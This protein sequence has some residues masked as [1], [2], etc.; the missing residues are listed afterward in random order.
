MIDLKKENLSIKK[1][2]LELEEENK[3]L[4]LNGGVLRKASIIPD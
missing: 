1:R 4:R 3:E 2:L